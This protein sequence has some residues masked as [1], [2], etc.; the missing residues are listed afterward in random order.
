MKIGK[1]RYGITQKKYFKL[2]DGESKFRILPP[3]GDNADKGIWSMFYKVHYGYKNSKGKL[4]VFQSSLV[5]NR[6][7]KMVEVP[8]AA[9]QRIKDLKLKLEE[10]KNAGNK[11]VVEKLGKLVSGQ[12]PMYN[13]DSNH[14][15]NV[16]DEQ[17]NI[18]VLKL[19][20]RAKTALEV[21][22]KKL[23][24]KNVDPLSVDNGRF[25]TF[26]R[27]G[28]ELD[29]SFSVEVT[30]KEIEVPGVGRVQQ[31]VVHQLNDELISRLSEE[32]ADLSKLFRAVTAEQIQ[33][34]VNRSNLMTGESPAIDDIFDSKSPSAANEDDEEI[35]DEEM[36]A[37]GSETK[38]APAQT[39]AKTVTQTVAK[40]AQPAPTPVAAVEASAPQTTAE[41]VTNQSD[42]D[43]LKSLGLG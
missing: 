13:L 10:A 36:L 19:R 38:A 4:R 17:G 20:H 25:F 30:K 9:Y 33:E 27:T 3:L 35:E 8:D 15:M 26:T 41:I 2:K 32:A 18:G 28:T 23:R 29:T 21:Q 1:A 40:A 5:M 22:I 7:T 39:V 31:E 14:Y 37:S 34:I 16:I 12:K 43:F 24:E 42:D 11:A 6:Q